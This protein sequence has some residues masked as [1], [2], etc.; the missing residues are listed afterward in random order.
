MA[1]AEKS[2]LDELSFS[3][4]RLTPCLLNSRRGVREHPY[5]KVGRIDVVL[6]E[7]DSANWSGAPLGYG[8]F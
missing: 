3:A 1:V 4:W 8:S 7:E 6:L 5:K 2:N